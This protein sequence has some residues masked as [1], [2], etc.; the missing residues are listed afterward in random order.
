MM[1]IGWSY[2]GSRKEVREVAAELESQATLI[3]FRNE[4]PN[5]NWFCEV[6]G[7]VIRCLDNGDQ[8]FTLT[9][10]EGDDDEASGS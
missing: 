7:E 9:V 5:S 6:H 8:T 10:T 3:G 1:K 4:C 2:T